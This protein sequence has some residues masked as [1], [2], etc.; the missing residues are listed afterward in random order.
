MTSDLKF[1]YG[2]MLQREYDYKIDI[3]HKKSSKHHILYLSINYKNGRGEKI[4][5][6]G[7]IK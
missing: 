3:T 4:I 7:E 5:I 1:L 6:L 2:C